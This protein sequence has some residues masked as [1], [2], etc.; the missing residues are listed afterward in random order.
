M[1]VLSLK[2][3]YNLRYTLK[4]ISQAKSPMKT[5]TQPIF[6]EPS[7]AARQPR[8]VRTKELIKQWLSARVKK[9]QSLS[10]KDCMIVKKSSD[11]ALCKNLL[12][13]SGNSSLIQHSNQII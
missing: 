1:K 3:H 12:K 10:I 2:L 5:S 7:L 9:T 13:T 11:R 4:K 8:P 6:T